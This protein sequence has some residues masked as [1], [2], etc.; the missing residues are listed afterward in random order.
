MRI[1]KGE[2]KKL[3]SINISRLK[4]KSLDTINGK[5]GEYYSLLKIT[6][7]NEG[8]EE[9]D[10]KKQEFIRSLRNM[11]ESIQEMNLVEYLEHLKEISDDKDN[12]ED[13]NQS[14]KKEINQKE[15]FKEK[16]KI[17][18]QIDNIEVEQ[19]IIDL[20]DMKNVDKHIRYKIRF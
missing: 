18:D 17:D 13:K 16:E 19:K 10:I 8:L 20:M 5:L 7:D 2:L 1:I 6:I 11:L 3:K 4:N 12:K 9:A 14:D 15:E